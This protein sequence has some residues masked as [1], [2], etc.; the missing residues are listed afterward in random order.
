MAFAHTIQ[1]H[2]I[3][4]FYKPKAKIRSSNCIFENL[5]TN[6]FSRQGCLQYYDKWMLKEQMGVGQTARLSDEILENII[7]NY[8][9]IYCKH[10]AMSAYCIDSHFYIIYGWISQTD[11]HRGTE[12]G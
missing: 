5:L 9:E 4:T 3:L 6:Q 2:H 10:K 12:G 7:M 8:S 11:V 1:P